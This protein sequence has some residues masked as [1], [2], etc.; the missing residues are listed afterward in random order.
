MNYLPSLPIPRPDPAGFARCIIRLSVCLDGIYLDG[1][2][3]TFHEQRTGS[4]L[5]LYFLQ[6]KPEDRTGSHW[7]GRKCINYDHRKCCVDH[8]VARRNSATEKRFSSFW[9]GWICKVTAPRFH[10]FCKHKRARILPLF[11]V[12]D[13]QA[14]P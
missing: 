10:S 6:W 1:S 2:P 9:D 8:P 4:G 14:G 7:F 12:G 3:G 11:P 13:R 5:L